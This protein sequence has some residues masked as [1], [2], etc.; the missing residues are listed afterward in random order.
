M[1]NLN[2]FDKGR[3]VV[4]SEQDEIIASSIRN[5]GVFMFICVENLSV[6]ATR[7]GKSPMIGD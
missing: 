3:I 4:D 7:E 6:V 2:V 5:V 1:L